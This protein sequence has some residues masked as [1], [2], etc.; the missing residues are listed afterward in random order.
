MKVILLVP[1]IAVGL[2]FEFNLQISA[3]PDKLKTSCKKKDDGDSD[4]KFLMLWM[5]PLQNKA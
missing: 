1:H 5:S 2:G 4:W 3:L